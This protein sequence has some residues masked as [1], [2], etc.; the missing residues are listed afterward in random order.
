[1]G[2]LSDMVQVAGALAAVL[3]LA[4]EAYFFNRILGGLH[5][6][7]YRFDA[8][9]EKMYPSFIGIP[10]LAFNRWRELAEKSFQRRN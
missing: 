1:M 4:T 2:Y 8:M 3:F 9:V 5:C 7:G 10:D 6:P